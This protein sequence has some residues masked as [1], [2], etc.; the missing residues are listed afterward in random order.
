MPRLHLISW[1]R[2]CISSLAPAIHVSH[3]TCASLLEG[4]L[5]LLWREA[6]AWACQHSELTSILCEPGLTEAARERTIGVKFCRWCRAFVAWGGYELC[7]STRVSMHSHGP[8]VSVQPVS[9]I[10]P[11]VHRPEY[12]SRAFQIW[13]ANDLLQSL[14]CPSIFPRT[15]GCRNLVT[16]E[17]CWRSV[18]GLSAE[19]RSVEPRH[20]VWRFLLHIPSS[21]TDS[22]AN[23]D[24][25]YGEQYASVRTRLALRS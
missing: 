1:C 23:L 6:G 24:Y 5:H 14:S 16:S 11:P 21:T 25:G 2:D 12:I 8:I 19:H 20:E 15:A 18:A 10:E 7:V 4:S 22:N 3:F 13:A 9:P 17:K